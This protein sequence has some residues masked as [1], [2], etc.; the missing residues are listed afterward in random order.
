[1]Q[2]DEVAEDAALDLALAVLVEYPAGDSAQVDTLR[3]NW[4]GPSLLT[5]FL[6][7]LLASVTTSLAA[8]IDL[9]NGL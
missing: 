3:R 1:V 9:T 6:Y 2:A 5:S 7:T 4:S 8:Q